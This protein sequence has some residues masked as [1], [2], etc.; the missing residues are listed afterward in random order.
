MKCRTPARPRQL[1]LLHRGGGRGR[2]LG[3][4]SFPPLRHHCCCCCC[5]CCSCPHRR[6]SCGWGHDGGEAAAAAAGGGSGGGS[7]C[8]CPHC[9]RCHPR[10]LRTQLLG[11]AA[12]WVQSGVRGAAARGTPCEWRRRLRCCCCCQWWCQRRQR[13]R[14]RLQPG[15]Q[16]LP[17]PLLPW[18]RI[19]GR[20]GG[21]LLPPL[22]GRMARS[23]AAA[24]LR[25]AGAVR[26]RLR[27]WRQMW[28]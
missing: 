13:W 9:Q 22:A 28:R 27:R 18:R 16:P 3:G 24:R 23:S 15:R 4:P 12:A 11:R 19:Q 17:L 8:C 26:H 2:A 7:C 1:P 14:Q 6:T 21:G 10:A 20:L 25:R 5:C